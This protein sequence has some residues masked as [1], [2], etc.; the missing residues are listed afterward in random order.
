M[1]GYLDGY[2]Y[3]YIYIL[4]RYYMDALD[5]YFHAMK[6]YSNFHFHFINEYQTF[7]A[8]KSSVTIQILT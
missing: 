7:K 2:I 1:D 6:Y 4:V 5:G 3:I 8:S